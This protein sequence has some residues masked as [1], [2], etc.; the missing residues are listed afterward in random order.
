MAPGPRAQGELGKGRVWGAKNEIQS[1]PSVSH[2]FLH[3]L[4]KPEEEREDAGR[5]L[6]RPVS[7]EK[8]E[9][10]LS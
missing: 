7:M 1:L 3:L 5:A 6:G 10:E 4:P 9:K 2:Q 8:Y